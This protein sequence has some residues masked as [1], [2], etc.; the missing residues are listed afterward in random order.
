MDEAFYFGELNRTEAESILGNCGQNVLLIRAS[1]IP[2]C[3][4]LSKYQHSSGV[5]IYLPIQISLT[6]V[7]QRF[8][9]L[10]IVPVETGGFMLENSED[11]RIYNSVADLVY[12][13]AGLC[14]FGQQKSTKIVTVITWR[15][16][17]L[18]TC[19]F[20]S[21]EQ[22][23]TN[24]TSF[25]KCCWFR[26]WSGNKIHYS[27]LLTLYN[28][29]LTLNILQLY[30]YYFYNS[31]IL[32]PYILQLFN[33]ETEPT[34]HFTLQLYNL[35]IYNVDTWQASPEEEKRERIRCKV[36]EEIV[37]TEKDYAD[38]LGILVKVSQL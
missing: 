4:A 7:D 20:Y 5:H 11:T 17:W 16:R 15:M 26:F 38:D 28:T 19:R 21:Q 18:H 30:N 34:L 8:G 3:F 31:T 37:S 10:L 14:F 29:N 23:P 9:H 13:S 24:S 33:V 22:E 32:T 27:T 6:F 35:Q 1:S 2:G 12:N 25:W 36:I